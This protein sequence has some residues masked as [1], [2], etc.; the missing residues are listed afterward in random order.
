MKIMQRYPKM[1][2][3]AKSFSINLPR[4]Q[5]YITQSKYWKNGNK[6]EEKSQFIKTFSLENWYFLA[7]REKN[8]HCLQEC[9]KCEASY[10]NISST[11]VS[12]SETT[13]NIIAKTKELANEIKNLHSQRLSHGSQQLVKILEPIVEN[14]SHQSKNTVTSNYYLIDKITSKEKQK[15]KMQNLREIPKTITN[16]ISNDENKVES[17]LASALPYSHRERDRMSTFF[18]TPKA[19]K[20]RSESVAKEIKSGKRK[21]NKLK[22]VKFTNMTKQT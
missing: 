22:N 4:L 14:T 17:F 21:K 2:I 20:L 10:P 1:N 8:M 5:N 7:E 11:H 9:T 15:K 19:A 13:E 3:S 12:V 16:F 6:H 18:E